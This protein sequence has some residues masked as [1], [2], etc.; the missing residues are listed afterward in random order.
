MIMGQIGEYR[1]PSN[2]GGNKVPRMTAISFMH[3]NYGRPTLRVDR[4]NHSQGTHNATS[5]GLT[6]KEARLVCNWAREYI[7]SHE[8]VYFSLYPCGF[9][10][11][12]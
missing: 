2:R 12:V 10:I 1:E 4:G 11:A 9:Y 5:C 7:R 3:C 8:G 6:M